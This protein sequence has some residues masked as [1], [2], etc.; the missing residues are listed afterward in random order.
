MLYNPKKTPAKS[1]L[2]INNI[3][4]SFQ[5]SFSQE[6]I[7]ELKQLKSEIENNNVSMDTYDGG[8]YAGARYFYNNDDLVQ[9]T[10]TH[11]ALVNMAS[12]RVNGNESNYLPLMGIIFSQ[13]MGCP[14]LI[15]KEMN[16]IKLK[17]HGI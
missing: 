16:T 4:K 10:D 2:L 1:I 17:V 7:K 5:A 11:Y 6:E 8:I 12:I 15:K 9:K 14:Y 13:T 3:L